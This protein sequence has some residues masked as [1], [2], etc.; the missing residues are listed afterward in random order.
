MI[1]AVNLVA[2]GMGCKGKEAP[3]PAA[4]EEVNPSDAPA[5]PPAEPEAKP[6][7]KPAEAPKK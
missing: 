3:R 6:E 1:L 5:Q 2:I 4:K 7:E